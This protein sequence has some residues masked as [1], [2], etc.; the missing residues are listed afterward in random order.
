MCWKTE[1][2]EFEY[3]QGQELSLLHAVQTG[4][5]AYSA[6]YLMGSKGSFPGG[7]AAGA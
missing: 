3:R 5:G 6:S 4:S 2:S 1:E 7:K